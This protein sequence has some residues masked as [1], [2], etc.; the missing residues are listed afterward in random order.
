MTPKEFKS[1]AC[2]DIRT[3]EEKA[4][5]YKFKEIV[6]SVAPV[7][8]VEKKESEW[9]KFPDQD[10]GNSYTCVMQTIAKMASILLFIKENV[11]VAF[12]KVY[13]Q[14]R[15]NR[16][17]GGMMGV[18]SFEIWRKEGLPLEKL[19]PSEERSDEEIDSTIVKQYNKDIAKVFRLGNHIGA[20]GESF[21]TIASIIQVTG[22]PIMAWFYFT[23]EEWS[24]LIP[25]VI[26]KKLTI[27]T[28]LRHSV[29]VVDNFLFGGKKYLLIEDSAHFGGLTRRLIS[30]EFFNTRCWFLR[31]PMN[32][33]FEEQED[34]EIDIELKKDLEYGM[35]DPDV[36]ILQD[37]LKKLGFFPINIDSTG[38]YL[39][40]TKNAVRDFQLKNKIISSPNDPGAGRCGPKTR[41]FINTNY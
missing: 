25:I 34:K 28:G 38:R 10:Q 29:T 39:S 35:T 24:R 19:V 6:A 17:L 23:A 1:G 15:S 37:L 33:R 20:D 4:K 14:L 13:Y 12:S 2:I 22:K 32:F 11:Y 5:D 30:E 26:D 40:I 31:Y 16:P 36:V 8:W 41:A 3:E 27:Q 9:R 21:E 18:E 7:N